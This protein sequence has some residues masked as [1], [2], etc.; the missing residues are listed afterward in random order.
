VEV[1]QYKIKVNAVRATLVCYVSEYDAE[2]AVNLAIEAP[3]KEWEVS[4][5]EMPLGAD[6][7]V[8]EI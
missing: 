7:T 6:V 4:D 5:F 3:Y 8:E 2:T 1:K